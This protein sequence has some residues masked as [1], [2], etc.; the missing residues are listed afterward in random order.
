MN[1]LDLKKTF[2]TNCFTKIKEHFNKSFYI[3]KYFPSNF[4]TQYFFLSKSL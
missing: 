2:M 3:Q 1:G 4:D